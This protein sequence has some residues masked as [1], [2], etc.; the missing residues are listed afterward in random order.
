M[1]RAQPLPQTGFSWGCLQFGGLE[2]VIT[3]LMDE[4]PQVLG[5]HRQLFVLGLIAL[6]FLGSLA[7]LTNV[8]YGD[9]GHSSTP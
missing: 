6:C 3:A 1:P 7:T 4:Y 5:E 8:S 9:S 2:A